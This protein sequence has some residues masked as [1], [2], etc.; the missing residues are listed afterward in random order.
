MIFEGL[1][2]RIL[3]TIAPKEQIPKEV[4]QA[5][6]DRYGAMIDKIHDEKKKKIVGFKNFNSFP[7]QKTR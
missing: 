7:I 6:R 3:S 4:L 2:K 1:A 5:N